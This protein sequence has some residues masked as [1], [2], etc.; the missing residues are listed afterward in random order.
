MSKP[1]FYSVVVTTLDGKIAKNKNHNVDWSSPEDKQHLDEMIQKSDVIIVGSNTYEVAKS[2]LTPE[3]LTQRNYIILT[4][5][6]D[7]TE[8]KEKGKLFV[9]PENVDLRKLAEDLG[10]KR[11]AILGGGK[12]YSLMIEKDWTDE[13][14]LTIEPIIF[15]TGIN[16]I[17][18]VGL[19]TKFKLIEIKKL[20]S[21]G[22]IL[23]HYKT[24]DEN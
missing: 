23:L 13:I 22:T 8:E 11:I 14:F 2:S 12:I 3:K 19:N 24:V 7:T 10:Y 9:N 17:D 18:D 21:A 6:V 1:N 16:F 20:N 15:G 4:R 5:S